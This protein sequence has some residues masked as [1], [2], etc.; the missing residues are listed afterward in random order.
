M[1][2]PLVSEVADL[3]RELMLANVAGA[4]ATYPNSRIVTTMGIAWREMWDALAAFGMPRP[5]QTFYPL[6]PAYPT[7]FVP[8]RF[9]LPGIV[10][11]LKLEEDSVTSSI[12]VIAIDQDSD[13]SILLTTATDH[14]LSSNARVV[15]YNVN[16]QADGDWFITVPSTTQ[17]KLNGSAYLTGEITVNAGI[18]VQASAGMTGFAAVNPLTLWTRKAPEATLREYQWE[19]D[20]FRFHGATADR[21]LS[22]NAVLASPP[23]P[24]ADGDVLAVD[25]CHNFL[26]YRT[27]SLLAGAQGRDDLFAR[28][29]VMAL[30]PNQKPD[31][32]GGF[33]AGLATLAARSAQR[34]QAQRPTP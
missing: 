11:V 5:R 32:S 16:R 25:N 33:L 23:A 12:G 34:T 26:A 2:Y 30:G 15:V 14:G 29:S 7:A 4:E 20:R 21:L 28:Y 24:Q 10:D 31:G 1:S 22:I 19:T 13:G 27:A 8:S 9:G 18:A 17:V 3:V 6:L